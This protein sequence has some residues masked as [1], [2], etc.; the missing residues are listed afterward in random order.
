MIN[1]SDIEKKMKMNL[2]N[3]LQLDFNL[4][5]KVLVYLEKIEIRDFIKQINLIN[6]KNTNY[7][8]FFKAICFRIFELEKSKPNLM[9]F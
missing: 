1:F 3:L 6:D 7:L 2:M 9:Y 4:S 8:Q 5:Y